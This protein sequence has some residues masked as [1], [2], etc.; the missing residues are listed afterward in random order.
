MS[1]YSRRASQTRYHK[2]EGQ[3]PGSGSGVVDLQMGR[4]IIVHYGASGTSYCITPGEV[5]CQQEL[6]DA[7]DDA[8]IVEGAEW[9]ETRVVNEHK[10]ATVLYRSK[11]E[12]QAMIYTASLDPKHP[13]QLDL[14]QPQALQYF[15]FTMP[16]PTY[17]P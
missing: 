7:L 2:H 5:C 9:R 15:N 1:W 3:A 14:R 10:A 13:F 11:R 4:Q 17:R 12:M 6:E 16:T 8:Q